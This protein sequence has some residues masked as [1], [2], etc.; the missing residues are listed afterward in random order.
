MGE[1]NS[2]EE[3][4]ALEG[5]R[6]ALE[7]TAL[8]SVAVAAAAFWCGESAPSE[9]SAGK[10]EVGGTKGATLGELDGMDSTFLGTRLAELAFL[11]LFL[12]FT[13]RDFERRV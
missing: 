10:D 2:E 9:A 6:G 5:T 11:L 13:V 3:E 1:T 4:K 12:R 7:I 8:E